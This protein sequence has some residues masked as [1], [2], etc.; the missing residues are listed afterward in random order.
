MSDHY[1]L[2]P[3]P[4]VTSTEGMLEDQELGGPGPMFAKLSGPAPTQAG[5]GQAPKLRQ[6][7]KGAP[8]A[9]KWM[10]CH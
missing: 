2:R 6:K 8:R 1:N 4:T 10:F 9:P 3:R 7:L 5:E